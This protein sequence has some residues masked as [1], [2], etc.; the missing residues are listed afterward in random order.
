[1]EI[2]KEIKG[3]AGIYRW[4]NNNNAKSY[5][6]SSVDL[7]KRLYRYFSLAHIMVESKNSAICKALVKYGYGNFSLEILEY[8]D[9]KETLIREQ[10]YLDLLKPE[11]NIL[12]KAGSPLGFK[13]SDEAKAK[14]RGPRNRSL[15]HTRKLKEHIDRLN[16]QN[17]IAIEVFD[18]EKDTKIEYASIRL[19]CRELNCAD[20][21]VKKYI[22]SNKLFRNRY[23]IASNINKNN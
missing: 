9:K 19:T 10:Y 20:V 5:V 1:V 4:I 22:N 11:Y 17:S 13:H 15:E 18:V 7:S 14:M 8:C 23:I 2:I 3:K 21:T 16:S 12:K 6:G